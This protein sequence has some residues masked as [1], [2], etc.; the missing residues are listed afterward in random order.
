MWKNEL[1]GT[2]LCHLKVLE[3]KNIKRIKLRQKTTA[4]RCSHILTNCSTKRALASLTLEIERDPVFSSRYGRSW[5]NTTKLRL[6]R[7]SFKL[8]KS[9]MVCNSHIFHIYN[10][11]LKPN[12]PIPYITVTPITGTFGNPRESLLLLFPQ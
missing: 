1:Q 12:S 3:T 4:P 5:K 7:E 6:Y 10:C 11:S 9:I 8:N 2:P